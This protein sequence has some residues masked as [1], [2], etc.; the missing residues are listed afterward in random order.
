[1]NI[2]PGMQSS[3]R[4]V[5][6]KIAVVLAVAPMGAYLGLLAWMLGTLLLFALSSTSMIILHFFGLDLKPLQFL[7]VALD[8]ARSSQNA[9][10]GSA[11]AGF[12]GAGALA[13]SLPAPADKRSASLLLLGVMTTLTIGGAL[14]DFR[15]SITPLS[16]FTIGEPEYNAGGAPVAHQF[17][18]DNIMTLPDRLS[19]VTAEVDGIL[20]YQPQMKRF[21]LR[22]TDTR[23]HYVNVYFFKGRHSLFQEKTTE[24]RP[25]YFDRIEPLIGKLVRI[26]GQCV[27]GQIDADLANIRELAAKPDKPR[28]AAPLTPI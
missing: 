17:T 8:L 20:D 24:A 23:G 15:Y 22:S 19:G 14:A 1:M 25:R 18:V 4:Q 9:M 21:V 10:Y 27:N 6:A 12:T 28:E 13:L 16:D 5:A 3:L 26:L 2:A 7:T 11:I